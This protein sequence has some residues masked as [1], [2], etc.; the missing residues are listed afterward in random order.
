MN[1][2]LAGDRVWYTEFPDQ[3]DGICGPPTPT[4]R[5]WDWTCTWTRRPWSGAACNRPTVNGQKR[6]SKDV[7][8][9]ALESGPAMR[10]P[11]STCWTSVAI[12]TLVALLL[13][14]AALACDSP[15]TVESV[16]TISP[17]S[18]ASPTPSPTVSPSPTPTETPTPT[19]TPSPV[20]ILDAAS[21]RAALVALYA[22]TD[23]ANWEKKRQ[24]AEPVSDRKM[25]RRD[26]R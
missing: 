19:P 10:K 6:R 24:M 14:T 13:A 25:V 16:P 18:A 5:A 7:S 22:A 20:P 11:A 3:K 9:G 8:L 15:E 2:A 12:S 1:V 23:G 4:V 26:H 17:A 21:D